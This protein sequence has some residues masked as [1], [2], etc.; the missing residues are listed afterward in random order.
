MVPQTVSILTNNQLQF[1]QHSTMTKVINFFVTFNYWQ[2]NLID[3]SLK[4]SGCFREYTRM[5]AVSLLSQHSAFQWTRPVYS[6]VLQFPIASKRRIRDKY[7]NT[8]CFVNFLHSRLTVA[9]ATS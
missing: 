2:R 3:K 8:Y 6:N 4:T 7:P 5:S 1:L 9:Q